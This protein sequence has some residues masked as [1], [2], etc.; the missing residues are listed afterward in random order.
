MHTPVFKKEVLAYLNPKPNENFIDAT[1]GEGSHAIAIL[2]KIK[3]NGK[4]LGI[5]IDPELFKTVKQRDRLIIVND[6]YVNLKKIVEKYNFRPDG[7][8]FDLGFSSW[9][10]EESGKGFSFQKDEPLIM[11][12]DSGQG[13]T[14][15]EIL[16]R[17]SE[18]EIEKILR[19]YGGE[20]FSRR[21]TKGIIKARKVKS[22]ETTFQLKEIIN[23]AVPKNYERGRISPA[24]R[25]F[26]ALRIKVNDE[27][28]NLKKVLP[29][30]L[31][32]LEPKGRLV[33]ISFHSL[34]DKIVKNFLR[35]EGKKAQI[36]ILTKKPIRPTEEEI[37]SNPRSRSACLR[38]AV[39]T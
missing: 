29:Q 1:L 35:Q 8:L 22:I 38:A 34:E 36:K 11:R 14:A 3:P 37:K 33:I 26:Q 2:E 21:I 25:T 19:E 17:W 18:K 6:S 12:Y 9:H 15:Q 28:E 20:R 7:I 16:N 32:I 39:K 27:L 31:K 24:T 23:K 10:I 13:L 4:V 30:T 5:E